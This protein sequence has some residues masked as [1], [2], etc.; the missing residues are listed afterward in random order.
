MVG[1][2]S[3]FV[4]ASVA[5]ALVIQGF[6]KPQ[7]LFQKARFADEIIG[8]FLGLVAGRPDPR[9]DRDHPRLVLPD[10]GHP[11]GSR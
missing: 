2:G 9:R 6:Y 8:G 11:A 4:A 3:V 5:F 7:P 1:F 10:P